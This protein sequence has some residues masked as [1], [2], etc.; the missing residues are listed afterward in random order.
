[1]KENFYES[2]VY[3]LAEMSTDDLADTDQDFL[4]E[5]EFC[6]DLIAKFFDKNRNEVREHFIDFIIPLRKSQAENDCY[7]EF[8]DD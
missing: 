4:P 1:M 3:Q 7:P 5:T 8:N 2:L 6:V